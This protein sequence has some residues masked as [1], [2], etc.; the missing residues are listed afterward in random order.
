MNPLIRLAGLALPVMRAI[1]K[2]PYASV[3]RAADL[4]RHVREAG[5]DILAIEGH[6]TKGNDARPF[7]VARKK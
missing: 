3:L 4:R 6:T 1:G 5:F 2:A 7:I